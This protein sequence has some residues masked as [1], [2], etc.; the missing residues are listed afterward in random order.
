MRGP[1]SRSL[2]AGVILASLIAAV[3]LESPTAWAHESG[4][5]GRDTSSQRASANSSVKKG[6]GEKAAPKIDRSGRRRIGVASFYAR[7]FAGQTMANGEPMDPQDD[8]AASK[9]LP[10]G[11]RARVTNLENGRSATV[12]IEDRGPYVPG[13]IIDVSPA[14]ARQL[15]IEREEGLAKVAVQ[16]IELPDP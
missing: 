6:E 10:L 15:G 12:T 8:N 13:R 7:R 9:T 3:A 14:T 5:G 1:S 4:K 16:P 2:P 11:T